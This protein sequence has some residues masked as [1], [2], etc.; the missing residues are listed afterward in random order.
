MNFGPGGLPF[1]RN[2]GLSDEENRR[3]FPA[4]RPVP[5]MRGLTD[6][7]EVL[8]AILNGRDATLS[9]GIAQLRH[10]LESVVEH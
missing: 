2:P 7:A 9:K 5:G 3:E 10:A 8:Y 6:L 4:L 1:G